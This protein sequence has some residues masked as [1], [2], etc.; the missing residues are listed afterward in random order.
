MRRTGLSK[1]RVISNALWERFVEDAGRQRSAPAH[2]ET[3]LALVTR[4][5]AT[6]VPGT[7]LDRCSEPLRRIERRAG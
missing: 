4:P 3:A 5:L 2:R 7:R 6:A 1:S